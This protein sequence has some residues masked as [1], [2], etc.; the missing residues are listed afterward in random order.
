M[1]GSSESAVLRLDA[2]VN[3]SMVKRVAVVMALSAL[4]NLLASA[5]ANFAIRQRARM[6]P[7]GLSWLQWETEL[8]GFS[9]IKTRD[10][11]HRQER[12]HKLFMFRSSRESARENAPS[13]P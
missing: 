8:P 3:A 2:M 13:I 12:N 4:S 5:I 6:E 9:D 1:R 7:K 10:L 11:R